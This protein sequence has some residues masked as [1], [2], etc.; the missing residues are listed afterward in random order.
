MGVPIRLAEPAALRL[1]RVGNRVDVFRAGPHAQPI[2]AAALVL[3]VTGV[4]DPLTGGLL[5]A[6]TPEAAK[7]T[8]NPAPDGYAVVIRPD[9]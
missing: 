8:I 2:A 9:G 1:V 3:A 6:L 5:V 7:E 4:D